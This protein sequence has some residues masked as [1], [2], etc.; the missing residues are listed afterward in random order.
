MRSPVVSRKRH[1]SALGTTLALLRRHYITGRI[2]YQG[3]LRVGARRRSAPR[4]GQVHARD[5]QNENRHIAERAVAD[6]QN[7]RQR[8]DAHRLHPQTARRVARRAQ[9]ER[10]LAAELEPPGGPE[11]PPSGRRP[12]TPPTTRP[13]RSP[14]R[15]A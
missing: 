13:P 4:S 6:A 14:P 3:S 9:H 5:R 7:M 10:A 8:A 1:F 11:P 15:T 12:P 2:L